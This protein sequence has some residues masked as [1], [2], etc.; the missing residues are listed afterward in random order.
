MRCLVLGAGGYLGRHLAQALRSGGH[1]VDAV[2]RTSRAGLAV[3]L[4]DLASLQALDWDVGTVYLFAGVTGTA[5]SFNQ[6]PNFVNGNQIALLNVL[7]CIRQS[8]HR[9][10][11]VFPSTRLVYKGSNLPLPESSELQA[12]TVYAASKIACEMHLQA[13]ASAFG[14]PYTVFRVCV[15]Y[16]NVLGERYSYG[17]VGNFIQQAFDSGRIRLYG[18]GSLRRSFTH[19]EDICRAIVLGSMREDFVNQ[20]FNIPGED[21]SLLQAAQLIASRLQATIELAPW[22]AFDERIESGGTVFDG[23]KLLERLS[24]APVRTMAEWVGS[25]PLRPG[26]ATAPLPTQ[27]T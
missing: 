24:P 9:P 26:P 12:R 23:R 19:V 8:G 6:Y 3:D 5:V 2:A 7:D 20:V 1:Q 14:I 17:T 15:P 21:L 25:I 11:V 10:R 16:G 4:C 22:P 27:P 13:Y 18:D